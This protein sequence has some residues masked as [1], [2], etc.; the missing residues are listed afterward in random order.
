[1]VV[2]ISIVACSFYPTVGVQVNNQSTLSAAEERE[3]Q[4]L[5]RTFT[6]RLGDTLD[7]NVAVHELFIGDAAAHYLAREKQW[8][9]QLGASDVTL[10]SGLFVD[11]ALLEKAAPADWLKLYAEATNFLLLGII[12]ASLKNVD[13]EDV[14]ASDLYP[15]SVRELLD[16]NP[17]L[18]NL[19]Q[20]K[21]ELRRMKSAEEMRSAAGTLEQA[22]KVMRAMLPARV[23][24]EKTV[25][26]LVMRSLAGGR[27]LT[28]AELDAGRA[29]LLKPRL[30]ISEYDYFGF[31][32]GTRMIWI[33]SFAML[34]LLLVRVDGKLRIV[35]AQPIDD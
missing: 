26:R 10:S 24:V 20:K 16:T 32:K 1:V 21:S 22:N 34:D 29:S 15:P 8:Q 6:T 31:P 27:R 30:K 12:H 11:A 23:D 4:Q 35:W 28:P 3:A 25:M 2:T 13:F 7:F 19:I 9:S 33:S 5:S 14:K 18:R 17:L